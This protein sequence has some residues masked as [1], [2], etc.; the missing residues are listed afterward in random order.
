MRSFAAC[1]VDDMTSRMEEAIGLGST[2]AIALLHIGNQPIDSIGLLAERVGLSH[3]ATVR[4]VDR[5][6]EAGLVVRQ[7]S[8]I[9][10]RQARLEL[11]AA[12]REAYARTVRVCDD[13]VR[14]MLSPLNASEICLLEGILR[15]MM[16]EAVHDEGHAWMLCRFCNHLFCEGD[17]CPVGEATAI[18]KRGRQAS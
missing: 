8:T 9:D 10:W 13:A 18:P 17:L 12:G 3:S 5:L 4:V 14:E 2:S 6:E 15:K 1:L 7:R 11:T 16:G